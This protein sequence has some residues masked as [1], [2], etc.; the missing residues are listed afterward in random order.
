MICHLLLV[1][2]K[3]RSYLVIHSYVLTTKKFKYNASLFCYNITAILKLVG[4]NR[5]GHVHR[6]LETDA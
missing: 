5:S 2:L 4:V 1:W 6:G 3:F